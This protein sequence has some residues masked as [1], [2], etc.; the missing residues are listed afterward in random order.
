MSSRERIEIT[1][2][3]GPD[4]W[5]R[6]TDAERAEILRRAGEAIAS[7]LGGVVRP[8]D[9]EFIS[10]ACESCRFRRYVGQIGSD[11]LNRVRGYFVLETVGEWEQGSAVTLCDRCAEGGRQYLSAPLETSEVGQ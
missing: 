8:V 4:F 5:N 6:C 2:P 9:L 10:V 3:E 11:A 7:G 1:T